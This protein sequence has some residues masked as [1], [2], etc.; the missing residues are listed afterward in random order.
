[1]FEKRHLETGV[2]TDDARAFERIEDADAGAVEIDDQDLP[3]SVVGLAKPYS[4]SSRIEAR[5]HG[6][7]DLNVKLLSFGDEG[8]DLVRGGLELAQRLE[9][10]SQRIPLGL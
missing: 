5:P 10:A 4:G 9:L 8:R 6:D 1:V 3:A 7:L 2:V